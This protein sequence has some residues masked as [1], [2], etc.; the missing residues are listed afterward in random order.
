MVDKCHLLLLPW[1]VTVCCCIKFCTD[2]ALGI[3]NSIIGIGGSGQLD[4]TVYAIYFFEISHI[5]NFIF[6][7]IEQPTQL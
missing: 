3:Y 4:P 5:F 1:F 6:F 2:L 7:A